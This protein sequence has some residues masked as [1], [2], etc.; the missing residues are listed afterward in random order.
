MIQVLIFTKAW[1]ILECKEKKMY[2]L[3]RGVA[4]ASL[5]D[6][7]AFCASGMMCTHMFMYPFKRIP[8]EI[9]HRVPDDWSTTVKYQI[10]KKFWEVNLQQS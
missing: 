6:V 9:T 2:Y 4:R 7:F 1:K 5:T 3:D 10:M 8:S